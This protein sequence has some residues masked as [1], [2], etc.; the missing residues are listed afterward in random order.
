ML[1]YTHVAVTH[2]AGHILD[3]VITKFDGGLISECIPGIFLSDHR[4]VICYLECQQEGPKKLVKSMRKC[5]S[6]LD[7]LYTGLTKTK[8]Y[9]E[10]KPHKINILQ[11]TK[12]ICKYFIEFI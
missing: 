3:A 10:K 11:L 8:S 1:I 12:T 2:V 9:K 5:N 4:A 7:Q 6:N